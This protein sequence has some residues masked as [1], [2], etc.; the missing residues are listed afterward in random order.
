MNKFKI[1]LLDRNLPSHE[2]VFFALLLTFASGFFD[3]Y[4]FINSN[5][6]FANAQTGNIIFVA[7]EVAK[8]NYMGALAYLPP[9]VFFIL[10]VLFNEYI[11]TKFSNLSIARYVNLSLLLQTFLLIFIFFVPYIWVVD[12]RPLFISF[13]CAMQF[14]SFRSVH[15]VQFASIFCTGNLRS[16]SEHI[17]RYCYKKEKKSMEMFII[18]LALIIVFFGGVVV[19]GVLSEKVGHKSILVAIVIFIINL[20]MASIH[21]KSR[22]RK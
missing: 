20:I 9:V 11:I 3:S 18:Y 2:Q 19:G 21:E 10:G 12:I 17:F 22:L 8:A 1:L 13:I 4:T 6:I 7:L 14:D 16:A 5:G 15:N